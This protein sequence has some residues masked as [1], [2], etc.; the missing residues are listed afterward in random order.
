MASKKSTG[1]RALQFL[2]LESPES[3]MRTLIGTLVGIVGYVT[4]YLANLP[5]YKLMGIL[6]VQI[7]LALLV[8]PLA[9]AFLGPLA[10]FFVGLFGTLGADALFTQQIIALGTIDLSYGLLGFSI[11]IPNYTRG[12]GFSKGKTLRKLILSSMAGFSVMILLYLV[13]LIVI[14]GQNIL[15]TIL[16]NFLPFFSVSLITLVIV[17]PVAVRLVDVVARYA[18]KS[19]K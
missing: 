18:G 19:L 11:G 13:G 3:I 1:E 16:Y 15:P 12:E 5:E 7:N 17:A 9:A 6:T 10:G 2:R 8:I 14:A 4:F